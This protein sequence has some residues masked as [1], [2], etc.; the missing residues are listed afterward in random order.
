MDTA[1]PTGTA[2]GVD[3]RVLRAAAE[4]AVE[5]ATSVDGRR[6]APDPD[7]LAALAEF[8]EALPDIGA[9]PVATIRLLH[10]VGS[11]A[12]VATTGPRYFG[13]VIG[14]AYP[15]ALGSSWLSSAWD[16]NAALP[17]MSPVAAK[18]HEVTQGWLVD[19][20]R[21]PAETAVAFVTGATVA[22]ASCLAAGRDALLPPHGWDAQARGMFGAP[23]FDVV[24]GERAHSTVSKSLGLVG[25]GRQRVT[26]VPADDQ[27]RLRADLLPDLDGP[28]LVCAQAGEVNTGAFDAF[29][30]IADW[31]ADRSGWLH[32]DGAFGL[33]ALADPTRTGLVAGLDRA[34]SWATDAHKWL[35]VTYDSGIAFVRRPEDLRRTFASVAGY[36]PPDAG[37]EAMHNTPQSSQRARQI[38]VWSVLRTLGRRGVAGLVTGACQAAA[39]IAERLRDGGLTI[40]NDVVLNQVLARLVDGPTTEALIA[41]IQS[42]GRIWCGPTQWDGATAMRISVS[43]WKTG[44]AD[45]AF[46]ADVILDCATRVHADAGS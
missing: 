16:Q 36:L 39:T 34:D 38:E 43:S 30:Q 23:P 20:L 22:N 14:A 25:L 26:V 8:D 45:A 18:L 15:V 9:D 41:E 2:G 29:D 1:S 6:V 33:W 40:L 44:T 24:I 37:F 5:Y 7:A 11:P 46:A 35:N 31:L 13:F 19:V 10:E 3:A 17:V 4:C 21:L 12:T 28:V 32:V 42:D 27:G